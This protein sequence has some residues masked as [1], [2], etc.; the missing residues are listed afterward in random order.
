MSEPPALGRLEA[1]VMV[2]LWRQGEGTVRS[3]LEALNASA[4]RERAY[5]TV[6]TTLHPPRQQGHRRA[7]R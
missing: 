5:T 7:L 6:M 3:V 4:E 2:E 1:A